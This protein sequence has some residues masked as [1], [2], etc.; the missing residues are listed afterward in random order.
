MTLLSCFLYHVKRVGT[1]SAPRGLHEGSKEVSK[2]AFRSP[3]TTSVLGFTYARNTWKQTTLKGSYHRCS[4][5]IDKPQ[6][7]TTITQRGPP[8]RQ[9]SPVFLVLHTQEPHRKTK[10]KTAAITGVLVQSISPRNAP[11]GPNEGHLIATYHQ[12]SWFC[13]RKTNT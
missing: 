11:K 6:E 12:C 7:C 10:H 3:V 13:K 1:D 8:N 9:L 2:G 4:C 5:A